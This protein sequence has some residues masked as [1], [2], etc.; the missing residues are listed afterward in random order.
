M[1][2]RFIILNVFFFKCPLLHR[3]TQ[4]YFID[5][6]DDFVSKLHFPSYHT[7]AGPTLKPTLISHHH[8]EM[9]A[10]K[11]ATEIKYL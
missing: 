1:N 5:D 11:P 3:I 10:S 4:L 6:D 7:Q 8:K 9:M 2:L